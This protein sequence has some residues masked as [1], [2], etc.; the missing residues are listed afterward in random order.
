[1]QQHSNFSGPKPQTVL[2]AHSGS[3]SEK[4][5]SRDWRKSN[6]GIDIYPQTMNGETQKPFSCDM[7]SSCVIQELLVRGPSLSV[8]V[9]RYNLRVVTRPVA[10]SCH[11]QVRWEVGPK[12]EPDYHRPGPGKGRKEKITG[13]QVSS[14][15]VSISPHVTILD[16]IVRHHL[17]RFGVSSEIPSFL[18]DT[19]SRSRV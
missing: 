7:Y 14:V 15:K 6:Q 1:M 4:T 3:R 12:P 10:R 8:S 5:E 18:V 11:P 2:G 9:T 16:F 17:L 13:I 19:P